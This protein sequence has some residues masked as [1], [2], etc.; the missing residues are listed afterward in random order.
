VSAQPQPSLYTR[1]RT[2]PPAHPAPN[3]VGVILLLI[4]V[5][6]I[7]VALALVGPEVVGELR[8]MAHCMD[9]Q[10]ESAC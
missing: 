4:M 10:Q 7:A 8:Q 5:G 3:N 2:P 1:A 6:A 9:R